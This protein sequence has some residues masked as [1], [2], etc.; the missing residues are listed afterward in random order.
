MMMRSDTQCAHTVV[1]LLVLCLPCAVNCATNGNCTVTVEWSCDSSD[2]TTSSSQSSC[3]DSLTSALGL[4]QQYRSSCQ[5]SVI[6]RLNS[7]VVSLHNGPNNTVNNNHVRELQLVGLESPQMSVVSCTDGAGI[8]FNGTNMD[9]KVYGVK[10]LGCGGNAGNGALHF[11][12]HHHP[13][14]AIKIIIV[15]VTVGESRGNG[16]A[17]INVSGDIT[18]EN[19]TI[20]NTAPLN[21]TTDASG[22]Y[23]VSARPSTAPSALFLFKNCSF[24]NNTAIKSA[25]DIMATHGFTKGGGVLIDFESVTN[26]TCTCIKFIKCKFTNNTAHFGGGI[27]VVRSETTPTAVSGSIEIENCSFAENSAEIGSAI[28]LYCRPS[29]SYQV[30]KCH[31]RVTITDSNFTRNRP[32][33]DFFQSTSSTVDINS[34]STQLGGHVHF[35]NNNG[36]A[37]SVFE[38]VLSVMDQGKANFSGN[39]AQSG[40][41][42]NLINSFLNVSKSTEFF[43][44]NNKVL[45]AGGAIY[46]N[47]KKDHYAPYSHDCFIQ[48]SSNDIN[49]EKWEA[50][51][52]FQ[53]NQAPNG[54][55]IFTTSIL[56]CVWRTSS[57]ST[58]NDDIQATFCQWKN[59]IFNNHSCRNEISTPAERFGSNTYTFD[60]TSGIPLPYHSPNLN[61]T[62]YNELGQNVTNQTLFNILPLN[63]GRL[64]SNDGS[65]TAF[66]NSSKPLVLLLQTVEDR[67]VTAELI[68]SLQTCPP[69]FEY[70]DTFHQCICRQNLHPVLYCIQHTAFLAV[71]YC[72]SYSDNVIYGRCPFTIALR[73]HSLPFHPLP[74]REEDLDKTFCQPLKRT[75]MLCG[76]CIS[77]YSIDVFSD[78]F[79][80]HNCSGS[81]KNWLVFIAVECFPALVLFTTVLLL[82]ISLTSGPANGFIF[83]SQVITISLEVMILESAW[84]QT[85]NQHPV[86]MTDLL[87]IPYSIWSLDFFRIYRIFSSERPTCLGSNL[88]VMHVLALRYLSAFYPLCF[89]VIAYVLIELHAR[90][91][92]VLVWLWKPMCFVLI[93]FRQ[94]WKA[95]TSVV[96]AFAAFILLSYVKII[97]ISILLTTYSSVYYMNSSVARRVMNFDPTVTYISYEHA[98]FAALGGF[99]LLTF[100][101]IPPLLLIFYQ[102]QFFQRCLTCCKLNRNGLR[103]FMDA[104]QGC[105][106]DGR[107]GGTDRRFFAGLYFVFR[108]M[109]FATFYLVNE[110]TTL[111]LTVQSMYILFALLTAIIRPYKKDFYTSVDIFFFSTLAV[112]S[113]LHVFGFSQL[114]TELKLPTITLYATY[115]LAFIPF[116]YM[117]CYMLAWVLMRVL[118]CH[119]NYCHGLRNFMPRI[120]PWRFHDFHMSE[121]VVSN[122]PE[123]QSAP[124]TYTEISAPH[125]ISFS[126][127]NVRITPLKI[128]ASY[129][130]IK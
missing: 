13:S 63:N 95:Q 74:Q 112:I 38:A 56:P 42:L 4:V 28:N 48:Y 122:S 111:Y 18:V 117:T 73:K 33:T 87:V 22:V 129:G 40:G 109:I 21:T 72:I 116:I 32:L 25:T 7:T 84:E 98:P 26:H 14:V 88:K 115:S 69:G 5:T 12:Y 46:S 9:V 16:L 39:V 60:M 43:F 123:R 11:E 55:S 71:G 70:E 10:F 80:C 85:H 27:S 124:C 36:S 100:G 24:I 6:I 68:I 128:T 31:L 94:S 105:Y 64:V 62:V 121:S 90:N 37:I 30:E 126:Q 57:N 103:I 83:S 44:H 67:T 78:T 59:W 29:V 35:V 17:F 110:F 1:V 8:T 119:K 91:C 54:N 3:C 86:F 51:F 47:Q 61:L 113:G 125:D 52:V 50:H 15:N 127:S 23:I 92:R 79:N 106:K 118:D 77:N 81:V 101:L 93:R 96:D 107:D 53:G 49:P 120:I 102:F 58:L 82:H 66:G 104:F 99:L 65:L 75:G 130:S 2:A 20:L 114:K 97:R 89:L 41:A 45:L 19:T 108:I 76:K 34:I